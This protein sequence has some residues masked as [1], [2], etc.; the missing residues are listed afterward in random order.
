[1]PM[2]LSLMSLTTVTGCTNFLPLMA[3]GGSNTPNELIFDP[4][5]ATHPVPLCNSLGRLQLNA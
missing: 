5:A 3:I 4:L 2:M 1:M